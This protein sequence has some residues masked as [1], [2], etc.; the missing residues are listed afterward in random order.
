[1]MTKRERAANQEAISQSVRK[2]MK[3]RIGRK[4][5]GGVIK[6]MKGKFI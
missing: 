2:F 5:K 1:M 3:E 4:K 6:A